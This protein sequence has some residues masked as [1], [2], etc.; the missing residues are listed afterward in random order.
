MNISAIIVDDSKLARMVVRRLIQKI[1]PE[2]VL[3]EAANADDALAIANE[4]HIDVLF[5]D[6][7]MPGK[8]GIDLA[9]DIISE[10]NSTPI[11]I[12]SANIQDEIIVE[13]RRIGAS[14][15]SKPLTEEALSGFLSGAML[16]LRKAGR[17][18][19]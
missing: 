13:A 19:G 14:F 18:S 5:V 4:N 15:L 7:N 3:Y 2:W 16:K 11:A 8:N 10:K 1:K 17:I 12:I 9:K 6:Y